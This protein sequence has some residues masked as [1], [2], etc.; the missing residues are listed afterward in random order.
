VTEA[1]Q[2]S[3]LAARTAALEESV[4]ALLG[5]MSVAGWQDDPIAV[6][7]RALINPATTKG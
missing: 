7:A 4:R 2:A 3:V 1:E 5:I 6:T